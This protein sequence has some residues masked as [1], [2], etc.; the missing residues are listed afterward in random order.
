MSTPQS[1]TKQTTAFVI[2]TAMLTFISYWRGASIVLCDLA[3]SAYYACGVAEQAV[4]KAAPWFILIIMAF[5]LCVRMVYMES[6]AMFVRGGVYRVV[7]EAIGPSLAKISVSAL[8]FD[9]IL[10]GPISAVSAGHYLTGFLNQFFTFTGV[11][12]QLEPH[13]T[14]MIVAVVITLY[15]WRQNVIGIEES[16]HKSLR[17]MQLTGIMTVI[18]L[19]W[20][21]ITLYLNPRPLPPFTPHLTDEAL[22]WLSGIDW[23]R[24]IGA[25]GIIIALGHSLL[26]MSGEES[27]AQVYREL[28]APKM[29]NLKRC[30]A[31]IFVFS[32][33][34]TG[35]ISLLAVTIIPDD[36]R[37][38]IYQDNLLSGLAMSLAGPNMAKLIMQ[39]FVVIVGALILSGAVNTSFVGANGVLNR[40][41]E[42]GLLPPA[43]RKPHPR[44]GT[45]SRM[46][47]LIT[48]LQLFTIFLCR[49]DVYTLGEAYAFGVI[50]SFVS[51]TAAVMVLRW[52]NRQTREFEVPLNLTIMGIHIPVGISLVF[53]ALFLMAIGNFFTKTV[54]TKWGIIFTGLCY[55]ALRLSEAYTLRKSGAGA[56]H[57]LE[58]VNVQLEST[59]TPET[60]GCEHEKR[61]LVATRDPKSLI[62][63][64][65]VL[66]EI[67]AKKTDVVVMTVNRVLTLDKTTSEKLPVE[68]QEL[69]TQIVTVAE[70]FG[71]HVTPLIVPAND[72][73]F[74]I[75]KAAYDLNVQE[76]ILG[77]SEKTTVE[78]QV[79]KFTFAW[80]YITAHNPRKIT[81]R[82]V[83][84]SSEYKY[85]LG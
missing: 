48:G 84:E 57:H 5:S 80:G 24:T 27:L 10:T 16:S 67:D 38:T 59:A 54:A 4:G 25:V 83:W 75:A 44:F 30:A 63:L 76:I 46:I 69:L 6:C 78:I 40:V 74:A 82:V 42:D 29:K 17:I 32:I 68:E 58:R 41:A 18:L 65:R 79:E 64:R 9:Y 49:G 22:G 28:G 56:Q 19:A 52:K 21:L 39:G 37:T 33:T 13:S 61:I 35:I 20:S 72:P 50:W 45:T 23:A 53:I 81:V 85:V 26:A 3:S 70:K 62:Q 36:I 12:L 15:F 47:H 2:T 11:H 43:M 55:I 31:I 60:I 71:L 1:Y 8:L 7:R 73:I 77:K 66:G 34:L 51:Q 14:S